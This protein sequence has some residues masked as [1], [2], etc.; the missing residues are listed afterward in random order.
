M[1]QAVEPM[2]GHLVLD[3]PVVAEVEVDDFAIVYQETTPRVF[4]EGVDD[5][6]AKTLEERTCENSPMFT[7]I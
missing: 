2:V 7:Y 5:A 1:D 3:R 6:L 4:L